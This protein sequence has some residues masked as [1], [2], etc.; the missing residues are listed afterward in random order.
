LFEQLDL[1]GA[2]AINCNN[3]VGPR[4]PYLHFRAMGANNVQIE[5]MVGPKKRQFA[6]IIDQ[7]R[8]SGPT[9]ITVSMVSM[10]EPRQRLHVVYRVE[11]GSIRTMESMRE[12]NTYIISEG[13]AVASGN[14]TQWFNGCDESED[15]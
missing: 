3:P 15:E 10:T 6:Y 9:E 11:D 4:N 1:L 12:P 7:A 2:Y 14:E 13:Q 8:I 5:L